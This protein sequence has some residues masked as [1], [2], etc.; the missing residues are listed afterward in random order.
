MKTIDTFGNF[1][2]YSS[3]VGISRT[4]FDLIIIRISTGF[5]RCLSLTKKALDEN[6]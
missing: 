3:S 5:P 2:K 4:R 1:A 6:F